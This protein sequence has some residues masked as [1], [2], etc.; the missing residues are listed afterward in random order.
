MAPLVSCAAAASQ[1]MLLGHPCVTCGARFRGSRA[2]LQHQRTAH[3]RRCVAKNFAPAHGQC[4]VCRVVFSTRLR[5]VAHL[6]ETGVRGSREFCF[7]KSPSQNCGT[8][9]GPVGSF[10]GPGLNFRWASVA[11]TRF[12]PVGFVWALAAISP[13]QF[14]G[15]AV[16]VGRSPVRCSSHGQPE[17]RG[18]ENPIQHV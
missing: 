14:C 10:F 1:R 12:G 15:L 4:P 8:V 7:S 9:F 2:L 16:L 11:W 6:T 18:T 3:G 5:L 13:S 17:E